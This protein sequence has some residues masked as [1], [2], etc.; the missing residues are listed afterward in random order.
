[1]L[2]VLGINGR[3]FGN[4]EGLSV[5]RGDN[6]AWHLFGVGGEFDM[7]GV[8]FQGQT[9][10][11][12]G[13]H[14]NAKV[15]VPGTAMTLISSPDTEGKSYHQVAWLALRHAPYCQ[16]FLPF[17]FLPPRYFPLHFFF[18]IFFKRNVACVIG[19]NHTSTYDV[20]NCISLGYDLHG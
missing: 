1:M 7:H 20:T 18:Q 8:N 5:C 10:E 13:N 4:L 6:V 3:M 2:F 19:V 15:V 16:D 11:V 12:T 9:L 17:S 14:V